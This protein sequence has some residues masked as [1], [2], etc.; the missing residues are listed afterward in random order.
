MHSARMGEPLYVVTGA[1]GFMGS[2][3]VWHLLSQGRKV[4][5]NDIRSPSWLKDYSPELAS[6]R[7]EFML[8]NLTDYYS[9]LP[10]V[11]GAQ[12]AY[13]YGALF[14]HAAHE[15]DLMRI[16]AQGT[17]NFFKAAVSAGLERIVHIGSVSVYGHGQL[18]GPGEQYAIHEGKTPNPADPYARSKQASREI[19]ASFNGDLDVF[20][21]DPAGV[22]G[23]YSS[24][25]NVGVIKMALTGMLLLP[26]GGAYPG[27]MVHSGDVVRLSDHLMHSAIRPQGNAQELSYIST[28][29][30][31]VTALELMELIWEELPKDLRKDALKEFSRKIPITESLVIPLAQA[32]DLATRAYNGT[33]AAAMQEL[34]RKGT[35]LVSDMDPRALKYGFG[36]HSCS[37]EK[38]LSTGFQPGFPT[39]KETIHDVMGWHLREGMLSSYTRRLEQQHTFEELCSAPPSALEFVMRHGGAPDLEALVGREYDGFNVTPLADAMGVRKFRKGFYRAGGKVRGYN[40]RMA[41]NGGGPWTLLSGVSERYGWYDVVPL[42]AHFP[43]LAEQYPGATLIQYDAKNAVMEGKMLRDLLVQANPGDDSLLLGKAYFDVGGKLLAPSYFV[44]REK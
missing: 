25:G 13:H 40:V 17:E 30:T 34:F 15:D 35:K 27:S 43:L 20:I 23:P 5:A 28:D 2:Q 22:F 41:Q 33:I 39:T 21:V 31:P 19:A 4:R 3:M 44:L 36:D 29:L 18:P 24:Y 37:P 1:A 11:K 10:V 32:A 38:M 8:G 26:N 7:L 16:N 12:F 14:N 6:G 42:A 9:L